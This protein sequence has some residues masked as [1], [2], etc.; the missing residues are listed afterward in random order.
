ML[1]FLLPTIWP[2][3]LAM[4]GKCWWSADF[5][6][7]IGHALRNWYIYH[8]YF[9]NLGGFMSKRRPIH[10]AKSGMIML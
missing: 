5:G 10:R 9:S 8:G 2:M 1:G 4:G 6:I 7:D 3:L